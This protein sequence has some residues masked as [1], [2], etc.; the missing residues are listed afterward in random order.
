MSV[1][2]FIGFGELGA[3]LAEGLGRSGAHPLVAYTRDPTR[4]EAAAALGERLRQTRTQLCTDLADAVSGASAVLSVVPADASLTITT[5]AA[6]LLVPGTY[7]VDFSA[8]PVADKEAGAALVAEADAQYVDAAVLGTVSTSGFE[9][10]ILASG[11]GAHGW[12]ALVAP[13]GLRVEA[14]HGPA[15]DA[16]LVKLLR[17]V[18]MKGRDALIV[19]MML[20]ARRY[21]LEQRVAQSIQGPGEQVPFPA[22]A[23]RVLCALAVHAERRAEELHASSEVVR[24]AGVEPLI[25]EAGSEVLQAIADLGLR[26][27]FLRDSSTDAH[28]VL[29]AIDERALAAGGRIR[30]QV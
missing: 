12:Q 13:E 11:P 4:P 27:T 6:P 2:A 26:D 25:S 14:I 10:P 1:F 28:Q 3:S 9:V 5:A 21:G 24:A 15:G 22:L 30:K 8:A 19:E 16:T 7:F 18:Y 20:S 23:D 17:S 29:T